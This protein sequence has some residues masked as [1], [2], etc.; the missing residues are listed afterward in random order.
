MDSDESLEEASEEE[1]LDVS[2]VVD[3]DEEADEEEFEEA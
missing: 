2:A 3:E 1:V